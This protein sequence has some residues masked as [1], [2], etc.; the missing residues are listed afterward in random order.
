[1]DY[2]QENNVWVIGHKN[3]DTDSICAA[4][5]YANLKNR[6]QD[7]FHYIPK[8]AGSINEETKY[9]LQHFGVEPPEYAEDAGAQVKDIAFRR[10]AGVS[11][12][13]SL[14]KAWELMKTENV[15]TLAVTSASDKLEGLIITGD[16]AESYMDVYDNHILSRART[17]YKNIVETLNGTL[18]AG[19]EHRSEEHTSELQSR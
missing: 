15:M 17:Q 14:K 10:T 16:I 18:L 4:I 9:V 2:Q 12:H 8:R 1:M 7:G 5:C 3:P 13:I 11:G 19:N 6:L